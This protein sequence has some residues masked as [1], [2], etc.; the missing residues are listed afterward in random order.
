MQK[1]LFSYNLHNPASNS[2]QQRL[3]LL[4]IT[5]H[6]FIFVHCLNPDQLRVADPRIARS[7]ASRTFLEP[8]T[9][10]RPL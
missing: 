9:R 10:V 6:I 1:R 5:D 2:D 8:G 7:G 3:S 4:K